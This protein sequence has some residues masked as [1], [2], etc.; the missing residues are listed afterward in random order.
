MN[1]DLVRV[2]TKDSETY[3]IVVDEAIKVMV[4]TN[5]MTAEEVQDAIDTALDAAG[6][7]A[8]TAKEP[9][10]NNAS[11]TWDGETGFT[12]VLDNG[13]DYEDISGT[14]LLSGLSGL[15]TKSCTATIVFD[16]GE[17]KVV[18]STTVDKDYT[19][20]DLKADLLKTLDR[21]GKD[22]TV[23]VTITNTNSDESVDY[24]FEI[25]EAPKA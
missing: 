23:T 24:T 15:L 8:N 10:S 5:Y 13:T 6:Y 2:G 7:K 17:T 3:E 1:G 19:L 14:G 21:N 18:D 22:T 16:N 4:A 12:M 25:S 11:I 9:T 20:A